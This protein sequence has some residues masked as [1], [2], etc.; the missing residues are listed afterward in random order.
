MAYLTG[1]DSFGLFP[2]SFSLAY[3]ME[4]SF[5]IINPICFYAHTAPRGPHSVSEK[6]AFLSFKR[7]Q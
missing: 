6:K 1:N 4:F 2:S 7:P 5:K 3:C